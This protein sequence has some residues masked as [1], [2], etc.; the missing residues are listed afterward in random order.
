MPEFYVAS[1]EAFEKLLRKAGITNPRVFQI[2]VNYRLDA[3]YRR[4]EAEAYFLVAQANLKQIEELPTGLCL[5][6]VS[7]DK[8]LPG[9]LQDLMVRYTVRLNPAHFERALNETL[10]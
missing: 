6:G 4:E 7:V 10:R 1:C 9:P 8:S 2:V 5:V 3:R